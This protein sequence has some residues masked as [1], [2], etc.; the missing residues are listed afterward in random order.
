MPLIHDTNP[1]ADVHAAVW[2]ITEPLSH[3]LSSVQLSEEE[4]ARFHTYTHEQRKKQWLAY[5]LI[6]R[7]LIPPSYPSDLIYDALGK[8]SLSSAPGFISVSHAG[9]YAAAVYSV[10][11]PVGIDIEQ[12]RGRIER[13]KHRFLSDEELHAIPEENN[14]E[15][16]YIYWGA[17]EAIYK[18]NGKPDIDFKRDIIIHPF[19]YL[20]NMKGTCSAT[21]TTPQYVQKIRVF[22]EKTGVNMLTVASS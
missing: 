4:L 8:P 16:L 21:L 12:L 20:C 2:H 13:V 14:L 1:M 15:K 19:E 18:I 6:L 22:Y 5:R 17:K 3:L 9:E 10:K 7:H 11:H